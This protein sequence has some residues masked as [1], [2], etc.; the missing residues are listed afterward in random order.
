MQNV[1]VFSFFLGSLSAESTAD[2]LSSSFLC[3][4]ANETES[5]IPPPYEDSR[6]DE[7]DDIELQSLTRSASS[8]SHSSRIL[9]QVRLVN[10]NL[11]LQPRPAK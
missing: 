11:Q 6:Q 4:S 10:R 5:N 7:R 8:V 9:S 2:S 1:Y 3:Q